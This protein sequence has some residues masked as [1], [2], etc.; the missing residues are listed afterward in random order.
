MADSVLASADQSEVQ[1]V[2]QQFPYSN[3]T[4]GIISD[5]T[6]EGVPNQLQLSLKFP[7]SGMILQIHKYLSESKTWKLKS[8]LSLHWLLSNEGDQQIRE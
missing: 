8:S 2:I 3:I 7:V 5:K 4:N 6:S 1:V